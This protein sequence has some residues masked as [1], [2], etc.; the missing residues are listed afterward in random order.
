[1]LRQLKIFIFIF[2][3]LTTKTWMKEETFQIKKRTKVAK[4]KKMAVLLMV[5]SQTI[6][7]ISSK[8]LN[9]IMLGKVRDKPFISPLS[10]TSNDAILYVLSFD[11]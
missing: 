10:T 11:I 1:M 7:R 4:K 3:Q 5:S 8:K 9:T 6:S 2:S